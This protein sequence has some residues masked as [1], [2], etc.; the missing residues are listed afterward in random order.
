MPNLKMKIYNAATGVEMTI[1]WANDEEY[2]VGNKFL[3]N[4][5]VLNFP[6]DGAR[7]ASFYLETNQQ[8][9]ALYDFRRSLRE[10]QNT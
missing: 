2:K 7:P 3:A 4:M 1:A 6:S 9:E 5:G 10:K 8:L